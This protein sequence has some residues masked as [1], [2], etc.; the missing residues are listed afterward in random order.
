VRTLLVNWYANRAGGADAYTEDL[1]LGLMARGHA[2]TVLCHDA[3]ARVDAACAV[4]R[5][6]KPDFTGWPA[7]WRV[8]PL[9]AWAEWERTLPGV[10]V[11]RPDAVVCSP[12]VCVSP[13]RK[14]WPSAAMV[15]L[16]HARVAPQE[17]ADTATG[18]LARTGFEVQYRAERW[19][20]RH[21]D[22]TVRFTRGNV[23]ALRQFYR[24]PAAAR[25]TV[26]PP[27]VE[28]PAGPTRP[29]PVGAAPVVRLLALGRLIP[30][31]NLAFLLDALDGLRDL[32]WTLDVVGDGSER[33]DLERRAAA[34][35]GRVTFHGHR[36]DVGR[37]YDAADLF[38]FPSRLEN[39]ALVVLEA[40][41]R[42]VPTLAV[43]ADGVRYRNSHHEVVADGVT[44]RIVDE[45]RFAD[46]LREAVR[47]PRDL[48]AL[49]TAARAAAVAT[50]DREVAFDRWDAL[51]RGLRSANRPRSPRPLL[52]AAP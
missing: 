47:N 2:V 41:A 14:R 24:L 9:L 4:V 1:A 17:V 15:Y 39:S 7:V 46:A 25:F 33:G 36:P 19:A 43:R 20:V 13:L 50:H 37:F 23:A 3:S 27:A 16:P 22:T 49:G 32:P 8:A 11:P 29:V 38:V 34:L 6:P 31:K 51:L 28:I 45:S 40:M 18:V 30:S 26:I 10:R 35:G 44:G 42:G 52:G 5:V 48:S 21:A 12:A